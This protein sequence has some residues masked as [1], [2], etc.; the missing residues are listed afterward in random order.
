METRA[1]HVIVGS[2]VLAAFAGI[3]I[4]VLWLGRFEHATKTY[5]IYFR[6]SVSGLSEGA[7]VRYKGVPLG[8]VSSIRL[9]PD[10]VERIRVRVELDP[11]VPIKQ[12]AVAELQLEGITGQAFVQISGGSN[13]SPEIAA[14]E[15][16]R[17]PIIPSRPSQ[18]EEILTKAPELFA[19]A[20][21]MADHLNA[22]L[23]AENAATITRTLDNLN[24][25]T[26]AVAARSRDIDQ[27]IGEAGEMMHDLR[28]M[29][30][31]ANRLVDEFNRSV[32]AKDGITEK[33]TLTMGEFERAARA[34]N[35]MT[36]ELDG[37]I[38]ENR[39]S[40]KDFSQ[41][42]LAQTQLLIADT[43]TLVT[44]LTRIAEQL[45]RDPARFLFGDRRQGYQPR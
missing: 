23:S 41:H 44:E 17:Y 15:D 25:I 31:T 5:D 18:L 39:G 34:L 28:Q 30:A 1:H 2:F 37:L 43:R 40:I 13:A 42:G 11:S 3:F 29:A 27:V 19:K 9:D 24:A 6:G 10:N 4:A 16:K 20:S 35:Q 22:I 7:A 33:L 45:E 21:D 8:R 12:D 38:K 26:G 32:N 36:G 14:R